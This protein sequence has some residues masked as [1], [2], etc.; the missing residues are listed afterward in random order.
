MFFS[1]FL[2]QMSVFG[3]VEDEIVSVIYDEQEPIVITK[4]DVQKV[5]LMGGVHT[6]EK[7]Q[8]DALICR[9][10]RN[11]SVTIPD[12]AIERS[13]TQIQKQNNLSAEQFEK[14][15]AAEGLSLDAYRVELKRLYTV[16]SMLDFRVH[17]RAVV[18]YESIL[19]FYQQNPVFTDAQYHVAVKQIMYDKTVDTKK[20]TKKFVLKPDTYWNT[21][22]WITQK[23]LAQEKYFIT[24][25]NVGAVELVRDAQYY[26][27]YKLLEKK[28]PEQVLLKDRYDQIVAALKKPLEQEL[29]KQYCEEL[30]KNAIMINF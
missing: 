21:H 30:F 9:D 27:I 16:N 23:E 25:M 6:L 17:S 24:Q 13:L 7:I 19:H 14:L 18:S 4:S 3:F 2:L 29:E 11:L 10:A 8:R 15:L 22:F 28:E 12:E 5:P 1:V 26:T 20:I